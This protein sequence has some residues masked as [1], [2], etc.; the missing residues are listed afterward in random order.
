MGHK[1]FVV[2]SC[3]SDSE[4]GYKKSLFLWDQFSKKGVIK[5]NFI[6]RFVYRKMYISL[7]K[8]RNWARNLLNADEEE[9]IYREAISILNLQKIDFLIG[10]GNLLL[11]ESILKEAKK[12]GVKIV[13]YLV[14]PTYKGK[15]S[16]L[17]DNADLV[18]TDSQATIDLYKND[19]NCK[20]IILS[21]SLEKRPSQNNL[22]KP[23]RT[24][25]N[26]LLV[27]PSLEKG[28]EPLLIISEYLHEQKSN[29]FFLC[30]DGRNQFKKKLN[31]LNL[32]E[33]DIKSNLYILPAIENIDKLFS[34]I[35]LLLL[36]S[37]WHESGSRLI[38]E[39]YVRGI[40]VIAFQTGGNQELMKNYPDDIFKK[41]KIYFD[42][43][44][45]LRISNMDLINI[46]ERIKR[47]N[48]DDDFYNFYSNKIKN[49]NSYEE[50]SKNFIISLENMLEEMTNL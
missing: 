49:E 28:I 48:E 14:N 50:I 21:K 38:L 29:I 43:N 7:I 39:A 26:C 19:L 35:R 31:Y 47:L 17:L 30:V 18:I 1:V 15:K 45:Q 32:N 16:Y 41:P 36:F 42:K 44:N 33:F 4:Y 13:F 25:K 23:S 6:N 5:N 46:S 3:I 9:N 27:N 37:I 11:E 12:N 8:T 34:D 2:N 22:G 20:A 10:W 40:P 24:S